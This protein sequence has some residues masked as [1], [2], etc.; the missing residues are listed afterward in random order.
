MIG[1]DE[2]LEAIAQALRVLLK[3]LQDSRYGVTVVPL[4]LRRLE[5]AF[6]S[7]APNTGPS[8]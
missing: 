8:E 2:K 5:M 6:P 3:P 7:D 4:A 1:T